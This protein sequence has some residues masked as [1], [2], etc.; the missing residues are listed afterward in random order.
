MFLIANTF[1]ICF[2]KDY[3]LTYLLTYGA[4]AELIHVNAYPPLDAWAVLKNLTRVIIII[5]QTFARRILSASELNLR[6][7]MSQRGLTAGRRRRTLSAAYDR[8]A[9]FPP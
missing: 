9:N 6:R 4:S 3:L 1:A 7:R 5:I 2:N 8:F